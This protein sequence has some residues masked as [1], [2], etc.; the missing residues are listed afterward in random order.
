MSDDR[1]TLRVVAWNELFPWLALLRAF[2]LAIQARILALGALAVVLTVVGWWGIGQMFSASGNEQLVQ[3]IGA[4]GHWPRGDDPEPGASVEEMKRAPLGMA[5]PAD[6][7]FEPPRFAARADVPVLSAWFNVTGPFRQLFEPGLTFVGLA[8]LLACALWVDLVWA[9]FGGVI[10]RLIALQV[11]RHE[12]GSLRAAV[13]YV[14]RR[15][16]AYF[17]APLFPLFGMLLFVAPLAIVGL[18]GRSGGVGLAA[19]A[20]LW[21]AF[22]VAGLVITIF[23]VGLIFGW[24]LMWPTISAEGTDSFDALSRSYSYVYQRPLHYLWFITLACLLGALGWLFVQYF[25]ATVIYMTAWSVSWGSGAEVFDVATTAGQIRGFWLGLVQAVVAGFAY[26]F[27]FSAA[28]ITYFLLR[29]EV[30]GTET[31]EVFVDAGSE[32]FGLPAV[33]PDAAGVPTVVD[34][35]SSENELSTEG[36]SDSVS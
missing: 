17:T 6:T 24:P 5:G 12:R 28:T 22:L 3:W 2:R 36:A 32:K 25:A 10:T 21:P 7:I 20:L 14:L 18:V 4:Y 11:T 34:D 35:E 15:Y 9:F 33:A 8:F 31:D 1:G 13:R 30:D 26:T 27:F 16:Q 23:L 19:L 29:Y